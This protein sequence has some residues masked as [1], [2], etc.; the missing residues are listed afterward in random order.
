MSG[1]TGFHGLFIGLDHYQNP[2]FQ[3]LRFAKRDA[4]VL[5]ALFLDTFV[6]GSAIL[7]TDA[8]ATKDRMLTEICQLRRV[9]ASDVVVV[10]FSGHGTPS[11]ELA[12]YDADTDRL[13][14]TA[15]PL[16]DFVGL[17]QQ[18]PARLLIV[19]LDCCFSGNT[20]TEI[21]ARAS[22]PHEA[23]VLWQPEDEYTS[24]SS[25][26]DVEEILTRVRGDGKVF[27]AAAAA[28]QRAYEKAE[29]GHGVLTHYLIEGWLGRAGVADGDEVSVLKL[30]N[31]VL[32]S[33]GW[34]RHGV[35]PTTQNAVFE[36]AVGD[37]RLPVLTPGPRYRAV[38]GEIPP[39]ATPALSSLVDHGVPEP[40][41]GLWGIPR[42]NDLQIAAINAA[43]VL[44]GEPVLVSSPTGSGKSL[45]GELAA[46]RA[47]HDGKRTV[48]LLPSRALV[49][50]QYDRLRSRYGPLGI[51]TI[52]ATGELRDQLP[53]LRRGQYDIAVLT[54]EKFTGL[55]AGQPELL[56]RIGVLVVDEIQTLFDPGRGP[57]LEALFTRIRRATATGMPQLV[58]LSAVLGDPRGLANWLGAT[59]VISDVRSAPLTEG[60]IAS[61]GRFLGRRH[62]GDRWTDVET[63]LLAEPVHAE[64]RE[65]VITAVVAALVSQGHQVIVFRG[66]RALARSTAARL[67]DALRLLPADDEIAAL[68]H[69]DVGATHERLVRCLGGGVAFHIA[70]LSDQQRRVVEDSFRRRDSA[71]RVMVATTT[72][73]QGVNLPADTVLICELKH[74]DDTDYSVAEYKNMAGRAGRPGQGA[75]EGLSIIVTEGGADSEDKRR[76]YVTAGSDA[77]RS[78]LLAPSVDLRTLILTVLSAVSADDGRSGVPD[79][80]DF[81]DRTLATYQA[82]RERGRQPFPWDRVETTIKDLV[83]RDFLVET[84]DGLAL[85]KLGE[86]VVRRGLS[87]SSV[88][89][90]ATAIGAVKADELNEPTLLCAAQLTE[91]LRDVRFS[92]TGARAATTSGLRD[93][94]RQA[95]VA[96]PVVTRMFEMDAGARDAATRQTIASISW[97]RGRSLS[98]IERGLQQPIAAGAPRVDP[99]PVLEAMRRATGVIDAVIDIVA[100]V[101]PDA[102]LGDIPD[103]LPVRQEFG[104]IA[105][106]VPI[107]RHLRADLDRDVF[108]GLTRGKFRDVETILQADER[109]VLDCVGGD[110]DTLTA[111]LEAAR[112]AKSEAEAPTLHDIL[113][114]WD[115]CE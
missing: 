10:V 5:H 100:H 50:E 67:A 103:V 111:V 65:D 79:I 86:V 99:G 47:K 113:P 6:G 21:V 97:I 91:E 49:N 48:V 33:V 9:A 85:T 63:S 74:P 59:P 56:H 11:R 83:M 29:F 84:E 55:L 73:A 40:F 54:Y 12:T 61:D 96:E 76:R 71:I 102:R 80:H 110:R 72:L 35:V 3:D 81:L 104:V 43:G 36:G 7:L 15:I 106:H 60:V 22:V 53:D 27:L 114:P 44:R 70:D 4:E 89:T 52:R 32:T 45:I 78:A 42:L 107:V 64:S 14:E 115:E 94:L 57:G 82:R 28:D 23:K 58:G 62:D 16:T 77:V 92:R 31:H 19:V 101:V 93:W 88:S 37:A 8:D 20:W 38:G 26:P 25:G 90:V 109:Q 17:V 108:V 39:R 18:I 24:R 13:S 105:G 34:H 98:Q 69:G 95:A 1:T 51:R 30:V 87:V 66:T 112:A 46:V 2:G 75:V 68:P 41:H